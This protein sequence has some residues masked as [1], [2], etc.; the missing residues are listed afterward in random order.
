MS[1]EFV[2][3]LRLPA[4]HQFLSVLSAVIASVMERIDNLPDR[5]I[6]SYNVQLA[7]HEICVNIVTHAYAED[8]VND[9]AIK[10]IVD[11]HHIRIEMKDTGQSFDL[12]SV[13]EPNLDKAQIH[14]YGL[15]LAR[16]LMDTVDYQSQPDY[17]LWI[18]TKNFEVEL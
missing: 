14:G 11:T 15:F 16:E 3:E 10:F 4:S 17:N 18:L 12:D 9:I 7:A 8:P 6:Q 2:I 13:P 1:E 5:E